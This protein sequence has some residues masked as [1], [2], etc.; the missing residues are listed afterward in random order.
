[1]NK[2]D[3]RII[4]V[5]VSGLLLAIV[6]WRQFDPST[7]ARWTDTDIEL[8]YSLSIHSLPTLASDASNAVADNAD[9]ARFGQQLFFDTRLSANNRVSC[10]TCHQPER[11]FSDGL[12]KGRGISLSGRNTRSI[13]GTAYSAWQYWDGRRDSLWAQAVSYTHLTLPTIYSV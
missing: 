10:A 4:S 12:P 7:P 8:L 6:V 3:F 11:Q 2:Q 1:M 13:V 9:A 5:I